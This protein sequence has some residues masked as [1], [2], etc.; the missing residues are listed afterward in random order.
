MQVRYFLFFFMKSFLLDI[1]YIYISNVISFPDFPSNPPVLSPLPLF[2][3]PPTPASRTRHS[4]TLWLEHSQGQGPIFPLMTNKAVHYYICNWS[5]GSHHVYFLFVGLFPGSFHGYWLVHIVVP[6][7][8][9]QTLSAP[10]IFS[11]AP[12]LGTL[13]LLQWF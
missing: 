12:P 8:G 2:T 3:N 5:H 9:L 7:M 1:F 10:W 6:L 13:C 4:S 11:I